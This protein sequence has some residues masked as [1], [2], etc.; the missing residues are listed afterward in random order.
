MF[1]PR[2][3]GARW[4]RGGARGAAR[5][6]RSLTSLVGTAR[7]ASNFSLDAQACLHPHV[8][9]RHGGM[10]SALIDFAASGLRRR[11]LGGRTHCTRGT[12][13]DVRAPAS[14]ADPAPMV[15]I[16]SGNNDIV[17]EMS[18]QMRLLLSRGRVRDAADRRGQSGAISAVEQ[19]PCC[20]EFCRP[21]PDA[22]PTRRESAAR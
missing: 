19:Y 7:A 14:P 20:S 9:C 22:E 2:R 11:D 8:H 15:V 6:G 18:Q 21:N 17:A 4:G 12:V 13:G 10:V 5:G 3:G 1:S 16:S